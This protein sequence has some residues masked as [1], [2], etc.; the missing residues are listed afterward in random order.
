LSRLIARSRD[1]LPRAIAA[2]HAEGG[3][4][5]RD[6]RTVRLLRPPTNNSAPGLNVLAAD[7]TEQA[8]RTHQAALEQLCIPAVT[9]EQAAQVQSVLTAA[10]ASVT[11]VTRPVQAAS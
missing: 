7:A 8:I 3:S 9:P 1:P 6:G 10:G 5:A 11:Y 4:I 2:W